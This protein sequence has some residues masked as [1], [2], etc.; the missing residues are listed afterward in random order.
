MSG[1]KVSS[2]MSKCIFYRPELTGKWVS[3]GTE[4]KFLKFKT[5]MYK[6]IGLKECMT[7]VIQLVMFTPR[8]MVIKISKMAHFMY[9]LLDTSKY[10]S[11]SGQNI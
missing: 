5:E 8:V 6:R 7:G 2:I 11:Q 10:Q 3:H 1:L 9:F 4:I